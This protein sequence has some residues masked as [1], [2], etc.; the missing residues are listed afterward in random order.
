[1]TDSRWAGGRPATR[2]AA[3]ALGR[4]VAGGERARRGRPRAR[5]AAADG[6]RGAGQRRWLLSARRSRAWRPRSPTARGVGGLTLAGAN[7][8]RHPTGG[9]GRDARAA[10][11]RRRRAAAPRVGRGQ[12]RGR[13]LPA[14]S[15]PAA[16]AP[17][18]PRRGGR[19]PCACALASVMAGSRAGAC[20]RFLIADGPARCGGDARQRGSSGGS[21]VGGG[22]ALAAA[23]ASSPHVVLVV[24][25]GAAARGAS[26]L[27][28]RGGAAAAATRGDRARR[29]HARRAAGRLT[30]RLDAL[31]RG[32]RSGGGRRGRRE[33]RARRV[34]LGARVGAARAALLT[35]RHWA[36][37]ALA[38][39]SGDGGAPRGLA[40]GERSRCCCAARGLVA[41][42]G[43]S[44][45]RRRRSRRCPSNCAP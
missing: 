15:E 42:G 3:A 28:R 16:T 9:R 37:P 18:A 30:P 21:A 1:M 44:A 40:L 6:P 38:L 7:R 36:S 27:P 24:L 33:R 31:A 5:H 19:R 29:R 11:G 2:P 4:G 45:R 25:D 35:G 26:R 41:R 12:R 13:R 20:S 10:R 39:G 14:R 23:R 34:L 8:R 43:G 32:R 22:G 17:A